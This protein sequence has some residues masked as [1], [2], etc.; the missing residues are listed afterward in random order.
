[1]PRSTRTLSLAADAITVE[2]ALI[3]PPMLAQVAAQHADKQSEADYRVP[4]GLTLRD[5]IARY[6][7]VGQALFA[8]LYTNSRPSAATTIAFVEAFVRDVF[9]FVDIARVGTRSADARPFAPTLE[10]LSGRVPVVVVPPTDE[11]D[12]PSDHL[13]ADGRHR[14]AASALQDCLNADE[15]GLWG[16]CCNG[17]RL[18]LLR[19]NASLTRPAYIEADLRRIFE[20]ET[21][22]DFTTLWLIL[23]SSRFGMP[24]TIA[25]DCPLE[26]WREAGQREG[27]AARD[28][29]RDG[30]EAALLALGTGFLSH[31]Q[32]LA[33]RERVRT[34]T[35]PLTD[36]FGQLLRLVY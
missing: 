36:F 4:K 11:L 27:V 24:G 10:A 21:F 18:R 6:F 8:D 30:V 2:G 25:S 19:R 16:L 9:G 15:N 23:H 29:L 22:A 28:R 32:N 14:S 13:I 5:E 17:E 35:L 20:N 33:L 26:R 1:M 12:R 31:E 34:G 7:R 3:A